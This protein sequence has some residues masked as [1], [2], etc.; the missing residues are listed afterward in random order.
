MK[1]KTSSKKGCRRKAPGKF[2]RIMR[3]SLVTVGTTIPHLKFTLKI[4]RKDWMNR[5]LIVR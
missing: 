1:L 4:L 3:R 2:C 5:G